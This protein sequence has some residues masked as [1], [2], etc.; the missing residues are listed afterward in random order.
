MSRTHATVIVQL[1]QDSKLITRCRHCRTCCLRPHVMK[2][3]EKMGETKQI[4]ANYTY[5][6]V[7]SN[8][9]WIFVS[10]VGLS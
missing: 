8:T 3:D 4:V 10:C 9:K 6:S 7:I 1:T 5:I 2:R